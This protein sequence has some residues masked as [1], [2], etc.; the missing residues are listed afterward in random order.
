MTVAV[1]VADPL[2]L[3]PVLA[4]MDTFP[5]ASDRARFA[6]AAINALAEYRDDA[7]IAAVTTELA[8]D[9]YTFCGRI[10]MG[11]AETMRVVTRRRRAA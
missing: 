2:D 10:G 6:Q 5:D 1:A 3:S 9:I 7:V 11:K 4:Q 8:D